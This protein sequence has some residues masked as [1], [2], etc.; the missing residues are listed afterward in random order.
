MIRSMECPDGTAPPLLSDQQKED[1]KN[2]D[3][4]QNATFFY[5]QIL[6]PAVYIMR[7]SGFQGGSRIRYR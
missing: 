1:I 2:L 3:H 4:V 6:M 7:T 5:S